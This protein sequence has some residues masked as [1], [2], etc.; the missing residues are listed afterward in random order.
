MKLD[1]Y[2]EM[3][4]IQKF[5]PI[6]MMATQGTGKQLIK[7]LEALEGTTKTKEKKK[8]PSKDI[9]MFMAAYN[10]PMQTKKVDIDPLAGVPIARK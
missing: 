2:K 8:D 4:F 10:V 6:M 7:Q 9:Q 3:L 1:N 5:A